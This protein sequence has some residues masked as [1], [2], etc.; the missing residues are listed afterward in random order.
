V[1]NSPNYADTAGVTSQS[2][3]YGTGV[4]GTDVDPQ[5][6]SYAAGTDLVVPVFDPGA[7][8]PLGWYDA[9]DLAGSEGDAQG[10]WDG[11]AGFGGTAWLDEADAVLLHL[12]ALNGH[13]TVG[14]APGDA[15]MVDLG[16][17]SIPT[18][19]TIY[20]VFTNLAATTSVMLVD[21]WPGGTGPRALVG[22][23]GSGHLY[24]SGSATIT[25]S[26][27]AFT[28]APAWIGAVWDGASSRVRARTGGTTVEATGDTGTVPSGTGLVLLEHLGVGD[29]F[30]ADVAAVLVFGAAL[31]ATQRANLEAWLND[32]YAIAPVDPPPIGWYEADDLAGSEGDTITTWNPHGGAGVTAWC[33][34]GDAAT[35]H[36]AALNGH[37]T[38]DLDAAGGATIDPGGLS[39]PSVCTIYVVFT[40][41]TTTTS[42]MVAMH[43]P[44]FSGPSKKLGL[45]GSGH[46]Y[47]SGSATVTASASAF[48]SAPAWIGA[49]WN[50][51]SSRVRARTGGTTVEATGDTGTAP[52]G[53]GLVFGV[54]IGVG[55][56]LGADIAAVFVFDR[57]LDSTERGAVEA[58]LN[59]RF[60]I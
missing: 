43:Q 4:G 57:A 5:I 48:T 30:R 8:S 12:A 7:L 52:S 1:S 20:V 21:H 47:A 34:E 31:D 37:N 45:D 16:A 11:H 40:S 33:D 28:S 26:G 60:G 17:L 59:A 42:A 22:L 55:H 35:L 27:S 25:A 54:E 2:P 44:V 32:R 6:P 46:A 15:G 41:L 49:V 39:V 14:P 9:D 13:N 23:D 50:G 24:A 51:A 53:T 36:L 58:Y 3:S 29:P 19:W 56:A 10:P 38:L 18:A